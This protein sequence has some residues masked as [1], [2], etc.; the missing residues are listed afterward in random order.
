VI[1]HFVLVPSSW[2]LKITDAIAEGYSFCAIL[3]K[4][5]GLDITPITHRIKAEMSFTIYL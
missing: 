5:N 4:Q 3:G 1:F 2:A